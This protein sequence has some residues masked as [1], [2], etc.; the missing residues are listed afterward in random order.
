MFR[1]VLIDGDG[2]GNEAAQLDLPGTPPRLTV[3]YG[4]LK[5]NVPQ[6]PIPH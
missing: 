3:R 4:S 2:V 5:L 6:S 1:V